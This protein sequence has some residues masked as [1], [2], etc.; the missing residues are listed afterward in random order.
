MPSYTQC[1]SA[2]VLVALLTAVSASLTEASRPKI[3]CLH[4]GGGTGGGF[5]QSPGMLALQASFPG[6]DFVFPTGAYG[7][8]PTANALWIRDPPGGKGVATT[9][10]NWAAASIQVL[11]DVVRDQGPFFGILGYS[12]GSAFVPVYLAH[13][14]AG[15]FQAAMMF[16][17][18]LTT[19]H[20]GLLDSVVRASPFSD[21][22]ALVWMGERDVI[23]TNE[24]TQGQASKF[25]SPRIVRSTNG[26]HN[27]PS[28]CDPTYSEVISFIAQHSGVQPETSTSAS[29]SV[30]CLS[31]GPAA[32]GD[33]LTKG[34]SDKSEYRGWGEK[35][36]GNAADKKGSDSQEGGFP[37][38]AIIIIG[39]LSMTTVLLSATI[40]VLLC[41]RKKLGR[42][43]CGGPQSVAQDVRN[44]K[45]V[46]NGADAAV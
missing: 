29:A 14:P 17:G 2:A 15:T 36:S 37:L 7:S 25:T 40:G 24:M 28:S 33:K 27:V 39:V 12:Q 5:R 41:N 10:P 35:R 45:Y 8:D 38:S 22:P 9:E 19:T 26:G 6:F 20:S 30:P 42:V 3:L 44:S 31:K 11:D 46:Q 34:A 18:Y 13:A 43:H 21:I 16:A 32:A 1:L 4:G 23:I